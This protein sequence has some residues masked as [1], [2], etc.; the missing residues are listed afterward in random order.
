MRRDL[1]AQIDGLLLALVR[2]LSREPTGGQVVLIVGGGAVNHVG[3]FDAHIRDYTG[4]MPNT[5]RPSPWPG[6]P[7]LVAAWVPASLKQL[8]LPLDEFKVAEIDPEMS[9]TE[10]FCE[11]YGYDARRT[12]NTVIVEA[13][14]G[15][16]K[17]LAV[18]VM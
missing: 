11:H 8:G 4:N 10:A 9:D 17:R 3:D 14:R 2:K 6:P 16:E 12:A 7:A 15:G 1:L 5:L 18:V 13:T